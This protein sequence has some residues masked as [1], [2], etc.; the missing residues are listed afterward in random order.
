MKNRIFLHSWVIYGVL[1]LALILVSAGII[2]GWQANTNSQLANQGLATSQSAE[3]L[4][5]NAQAK[6]ESAGQRAL[7]QQAAAEIEAQ[8]A[9]SLQ[10]TAESDAQQRALV[11][12]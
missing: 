9:R 5:R 8:T 7:E 2:Y 10:A 12:A 1:G 6:A 11:E 3:Q 4:A